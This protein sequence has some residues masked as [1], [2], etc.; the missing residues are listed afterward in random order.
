MAIWDSAS[1]TS[2][3]VIGAWSNFTCSGLSVGGLLF[4]CAKYTSSFPALSP[5]SNIR[6]LQKNT[7]C[8]AF[9]MCI[10]VTILAC[11]LTLCKL[12]GLGSRLY[13]VSISRSLSDDICK[14]SLEDHLNLFILDD[15]IL[16]SCSLN[17]SHSL[18]LLVILRLS[19]RIYFS[20]S[21]I[22]SRFGMTDSKNGFSL[23]MRVGEDLSKETVIQH[24]EWT[25]RPPGANPDPVT[26]GRRVLD[27][28]I[29][30]ILDIV[31]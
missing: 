17:T 29:K 27:T 28:N 25:D 15:K 8:L 1:V 10:C 7:C 4:K 5:C 14:I 30:S 20:S 3:C 18:A 12:S 6:C 23:Q 16:R 9:S 2:F 19:F 22:A 11:S 13:S 26:L 21:E 24:G 31:L